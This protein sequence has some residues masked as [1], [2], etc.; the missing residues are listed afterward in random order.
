V[1]NNLGFSCYLCGQYEGALEALDRAVA[2]GNRLSTTLY[3][4]AV[5]HHAMAMKARREPVEAM[6]D[7][8]RLVSLGVRSARS[9][10]RAAVIYAHASRYD[11]SWKSAAQRYVDLA[12]RHG[13]PAASMRAHP[14]LSSF[15]NEE[16]P[17]PRRLGETRGAEDFDVTS[18]FLNP[19]D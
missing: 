13:V 12:M 19:L 15:M 1:Y 3:N 16:H 18:H 8:D 9:Y 14:L 2:L 10:Y 4:R 6:R 11:A 17:G 5:V 7:I